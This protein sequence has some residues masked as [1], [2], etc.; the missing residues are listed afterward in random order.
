MYNALHVY[1]VI[2]IC[3]YICIYIKLFSKAISEWP[4]YSSK[5]LLKDPSPLNK[6]LQ[7]W[8]LQGRANPVPVLIRKRALVPKETAMSRPPIKSGVL[9]FDLVLTS[10]SMV[11]KAAVAG[12]WHG[13]RKHQDLASDNHF[14]RYLPMG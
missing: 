5:H 12:V 14:L 2:N 6:T 8:F 1:T 11:R 9:K 7:A 4:E 3:I 10:G 13:S